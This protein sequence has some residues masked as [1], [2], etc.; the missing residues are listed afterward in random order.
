MHLQ[1][2]PPTTCTALVYFPQYAIT[3]GHK[4]QIQK[5]NSTQYVMIVLFHNDSFVKTEGCSKLQSKEA[6]KM[7]TNSLLKHGSEC[8]NSAL[9]IIIN[10]FKHLNLCI[11]K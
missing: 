5:M 7:K 6:D 10:F 2:R 8:V 1:L 9:Y 11:G 3:V 4:T